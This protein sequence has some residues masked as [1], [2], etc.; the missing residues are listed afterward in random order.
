MGFNLNR[1]Q[2]ADYTLKNNHINELI[3]IYGVEA[4]F[5]FTEKVNA[6]KVLMDFSHMK[7]DK[8]TLKI[9]LLPEESENWGGSSQWDAFGL[10]NL[11]TMSFFISSKTIN[12]MF[13]KYSVSNYKEYINSLVVLPN[14]SF[15]EITD[16]E[17][18][19]DGINNLYTYSDEKSVYRVTAKAYTHNKQDE[20]EHSST[21]TEA[22]TIDDTTIPGIKMVDYSDDKIIDDS[23]MDLDEFFNSLEEDKVTQDTEGTEISNSDGVFG[24]LG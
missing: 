10:N 13:D 7:S 14:K 12:E 1:T 8:N 17:A 11:R 24:S 23:S 22:I 5:I 9:L 15:L 2:S 3:K 19:V 4:D 21:D 18:E 6:D 16:I 20:I